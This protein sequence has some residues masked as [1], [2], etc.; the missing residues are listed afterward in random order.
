MARL[1]AAKK[2]SDDDGTNLMPFINFLVVLIPVLMLSAEFQAI[3][4]I[5]TRLPNAGAR[6][7]SVSIQKPDIDKLVICVGD[8]SVVI[9]ADDR[10]VWS[11]NFSG[12]VSFPGEALDT[13]L[14]TI[15][16]QLGLDMDQII[17]AS[18]ANV[19]YQ[20]VIDVMDFAKKNGF[21]DI[22]ITRWRG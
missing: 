12:A 13:A 18:D 19:K 16:G 17:V 9:A 22:A 20:R 8:S 6:S 7:D 5:D 14:Q 2:L 1:V 10:L 11:R 21:S 3:N 4:V 15:R